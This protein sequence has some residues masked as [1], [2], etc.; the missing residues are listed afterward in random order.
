MRMW[1]KTLVNMIGDDNDDDQFQQERVHCDGGGG[2]HEC[3]TRKGGD[4][5]GQG[6]QVGGWGGQDGQH[7]HYHH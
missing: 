2:S 5:G 1:L 7:Q 6:T 4:Q 3:E